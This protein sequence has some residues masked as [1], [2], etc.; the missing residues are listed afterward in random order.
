MHKLLKNFLSTSVANVV[1]QLV[2]FISILYYSRVIEEYNFGVIA[3]AQQFVL[4]CTIIVL[5]GVQTFGT[6]LVIN[7]EKEESLLLSEISSFRLI[8]SC[9]LC[10]LC[11]LCC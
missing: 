9:I 3:Y 7:K 10:V 2:G 4:Y 1:G 8:I 5:F 6:K 11:I